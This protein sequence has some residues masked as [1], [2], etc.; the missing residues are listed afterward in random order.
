MASPA[1][2]TRA[3]GTRRASRA[4]A[5]PRTR[6]AG[7]LPPGVEESEEKINDVIEWKTNFDQTAKCKKIPL[8]AKIRLDFNEITL[9]DLTKFMS[10]VTEQNFLLT[11][12]VNKTATIS[13]LSPKPVTAFE[14]Y[15]AYLSALEA[16]GLTIVPSGAFLKIVPVGEARDKTPI[17]GTR[18]SGP[19]TA[20]MV[21]RLIQ[22]DHIQAD[23]ILPVIEKFKSGA[24]DITVYG[25]TNTLIITDSGENIRRLMK[26]IGDLDV[27]VGKERIWIPPGRERERLGDRDVARADYW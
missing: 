4:T 12:S 3:T 5:R 25:P 19:N 10:C 20:Q 13:I 1:S 2:S 22:L 14:A 24:A 16:N 8:D 18:Q 6:P 23:E 27:P 11:G 21:T 17:I 9:G 7:D 26:L 15:K